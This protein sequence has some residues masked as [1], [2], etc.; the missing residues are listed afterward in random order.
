M[1]AS[2]GNFSKPFPAAV[3][4][5]GSSQFRR[6]PAWRR[7]KA[8]LRTCRQSDQYVQLLHGGEYMAPA[9]TPPGT[10]QPPGPQPPYP[11]PP[12]PQPVPQQGVQQQPVTTAVNNRPNPRR[13]RRFMRESFRWVAVHPAQSPTDAGR[14]PGGKGC[15]K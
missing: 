7:L 11:Q 9:G 5:L 3:R 8:E 15:V 4:S 2:A 10:V 1:P 14:L 6:R 13:M 12:K